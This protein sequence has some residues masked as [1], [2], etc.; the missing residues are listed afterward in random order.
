MVNPLVF[1][2]S[3]WVQSTCRNRNEVISRCSFLLILIAFFLCCTNCCGMA[4]RASFILRSP[5]RLSG[6]TTITRSFFSS[7][8]INSGKRLLNLNPWLIGSFTAVIAATGASYVANKGNEMDCGILQSVKASAF[9]SLP[10]LCSKLQKCSTSCCD[11]N[12]ESSLRMRLH[13]NVL[14][15]NSLFLHCTTDLV[16]IH[17]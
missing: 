16:A 13:H 15:M 2:I 7:A 8:R 9:V 3:L 17:L 11:F 10:L 1:L 14:V 6:A 5:Q 4:S 12:P